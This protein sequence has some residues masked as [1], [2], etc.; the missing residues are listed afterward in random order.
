MDEKA[1]ARLENIYKFV[2]GT[3]E[4]IR[5]MIRATADGKK[6]VKVEDILNAIDII[7]RSTWKGIVSG[8]TKD[9]EKD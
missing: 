4:A 9:E 1:K 6:K 3:Y 5:S 7:E 8:L 2:D